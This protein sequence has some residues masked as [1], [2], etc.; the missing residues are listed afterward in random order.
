M[1]WKPTWWKR[2]RPRSEG[3]RSAAMVIGL[4]LLDIHFPHARSLKDKRHHLHRIKDRIRQKYNVAVAELDFQDKW[5]RTQIGLVTIS[6]EKQLVENALNRIR[7]EIQETTEGEV[8]SA[9]IQLL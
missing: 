5:Q 8:L 6:N 9:E 7:A 4:L 1:S 3:L 2:S